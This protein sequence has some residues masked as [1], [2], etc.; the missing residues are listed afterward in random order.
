MPFFCFSQCI[1]RRFAEMEALTVLAALVRHFDF[2]LDESKPVVEKS[3]I[4]LTSEDGIWVKATPRK[5]D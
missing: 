4:T 2:V 1:G 3:H 5:H